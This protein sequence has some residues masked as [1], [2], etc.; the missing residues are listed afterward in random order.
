MQIKF[1]LFASAL[2]KHV[3]KQCYSDEADE[4]D[5][6]HM[7]LGSECARGCFYLGAGLGAKGL[8]LEPLRSLHKCDSDP[9][10]SLPTPK[11]PS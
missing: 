6:A 2:S 7:R 5:E 8:L 10:G 4:A 11:N 1:N 3:A 9:Y